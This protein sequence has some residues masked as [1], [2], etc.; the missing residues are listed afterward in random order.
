MTSQEFE[1][2][3]GKATMMEKADQDHQT[4][5]MG[6]SWG[7]RSGFSE[8][9]FLRDEEHALWWLLAEEKDISRRE[10]GLGYRA[11]FRCAVLGPAYCSDNRFCCET[12][13]LTKKGL[14]CQNNLL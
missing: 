1:A 6:Y 12:C 11:G 3:M 10:R 4:F 7:L 2:E 5:W 14:D 9:E 8:G 13:P